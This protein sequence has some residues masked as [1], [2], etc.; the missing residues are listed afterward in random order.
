MR[1]A[2]TEVPCFTAI[3]Q[4]WDC[5]S[6]IEPNLGIQLDDRL[7]DCFLIKFM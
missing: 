6:L 7:P 5:V 2:D 4:D 1:Q 3:H